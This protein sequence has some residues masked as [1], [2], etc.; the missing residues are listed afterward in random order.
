M[1]TRVLLL[2]VFLTTACSKL[3]SQSG[4]PGCGGIKRY[5]TPLGDNGRIISGNPSSMWY[6]PVNPGDTIVISNQHSW[7]FVRIEEYSGTPSCPIT[8]INEGGQVWLTGGIQTESCKYFRITGSGH[9]NV[10]Y[11]FK[12]YN[13]QADNAGVAVSIEGKARSI[14][15]E[16]IDVYRKTYGV[17][18]KQDPKCDVSFN[19]PNYVMD[20][21][22]IHH[23]RF[24]NIGQ[25]C[26][27][28][29]NTDPA[30]T[31]TYNCNGQTMQFIPMRM[32]NVS[33]HH[34]LI[35]SCNR[36]AIQL[37]G[38]DHGVNRIYD[39]I[40]TNTGYEFNQQQGTGISIGGMTTN[41]YVYNN[42][43]KNTF[44]YG[45]LDLGAGNSYITNNIVD[46]SGYIPINPLVDIDS[47]AN[48]LGL[49]YNGQVLKNNMVGGIK[50]IQ[51]TT[52]PTVPLTIK[53]VFYKDNKLGANSSVIAPDG[54]ITFSEWGPAVDWSS[55][56]KVCNN[57]LLNG[58]TPAHIEKFW[59]TGT[60]QLFP[61]MD[62]ICGSLVNNPPVANAGQDLA[63]ISDSFFLSGS[64]S[65]M[66]G[67]IV[68]YKWTRVAGPG[69]FNIVNPLQPHTDVTGIAAGIHTFRLTVYDN[70]G[71]EGSDDVQVSF[72]ASNLPPSSNAGIAV[73]V[74]L[75]KDSVLLTGGG[76]DADGII[77]SYLWNKIS[78]P[79]Q[80]QIENPSSAVTKIRSLVTGVYKFELTVT[81]NLGAFESDTLTV[82]VNEPPIVS[83]GQ[84]V[85][86]TLPVNQVQLN[87]TAVDNNGWLYYVQW[88]K[89]SG[90]SAFAISS[91]YQ[92]STMIT[93]LLEGIYQFEFSAHDNQGGVSRDTVKITVL[94]GTNIAP[95]ANAG[96]S[97]T[98]TLPVNSV[99]LSGSGTDMDG[100]VISYQWSK[101][102]GPGSFTIT[103][104]NSVQTSVT[105][106]VQGQ[107]VFNL[108]VTDDDGA[109]GNATVM[110]TVNA[111]VVVPNILPV[112]NAGTGQTITLPVNSV[113]LTG[114]GTDADGTI[115]TY[116]WKKIS[117]PG[118][119]VFNNATSAHTMV[120]ALIQ[121]QYI[122][123][124]KVIDDDGGAD[125]ASVQVIVNAEG[126]IQNILPQANVGTNQ[127]ITLP[128]NSAN[129]HGTGTDADGTVVSFYWKKIS[130]PAGSVI[131][132]ANSAQTIVT[133]LVQ[134]QYIFQ[135]KVV[136]DDGGA[137]SASMAITVKPSV[138]TAN[139]IPVANAGFNQS[140]TLP[141]NSVILTG[142]GTDADGTV[143]SYK[144][145]KLSGPQAILSTVTHPEITLTNLVQG[146]YLF[147]LAVTDN[148]GAIGKDTVIVYVNDE[149]IV[150]GNASVYPNPVDLK[151]N[152]KI[153][154]P[155]AK[156]LTEIF[157]YDQSGRL[158][159]QEKF[160]RDDQQ[161]IRKIDVARL[162]P[163]VY[164]IQYNST[165]QKKNSIK[166]IKE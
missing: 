151:L 22:E 94:P 34:L 25:D 27:Y 84:D 148:L 120:G 81:D 128:A 37:S 138:Q 125:S 68:S 111:A 43:I 73:T 132:N 24:K 93:G 19:Y 4:S 85:T 14:E 44:L 76:S 70:N 35:D 69:S 99:T 30:G 97:Q 59:F 48:A 88:N 31:R 137:D 16:R 156:N 157:I 54:V 89:I 7:N 61:L 161:V 142:S 129:L 57:T 122:F 23:S 102:S 116:Q 9:P 164:I 71:N 67:T 105:G 60:S 26:I 150:L 41:C 28:A 121:G 153:D 32:G 155:T 140:I 107:Y 52:K 63:S 145:K 154:A 162:K 141:V 104:P 100:T 11:G 66:D 146:T 20:S 80:F 55:N 77:I 103:N 5:L 62:T 139:S 95:I 149:L 130:G 3:Y 115:V 75:P 49:T 13:P 12:M 46:S 159:Y 109:I 144:W 40:I 133:G 56:N 33:I 86:I 29:G 98:I 45:I 90:P 21:I 92:G 2:V 47:L 10:F 87:G 8:V 158:V 126:T 143:A 118:S 1:K 53:T 136:D 15:V 50:N 42:S 65:D 78:G 117:G 131:A 72:N 114:S 134:G 119:F 79:S 110:I 127:T 64:G 38:S 147:E 163:G 123:Q 108:K 74:H 101:S 124:L 36:T 152:L 160:M 82:Y 166:F 165:L 6:F 18:A 113:N 83:A 106:L 39:N 96:A 112:A 91:A 51:S 17:W 58:S 135:L